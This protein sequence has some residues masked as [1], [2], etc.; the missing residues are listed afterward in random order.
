MSDSLKKTRE[1]YNGLA[2]T[3]DRI[4]ASNEPIIDDVNLFLELLRG[5]LVLDVGCGHGRDS[6]FF[7]NRGLTTVGF[8]LSI[9]LIR[10]AMNKSEYTCYVMADMRYP[11]F[12]A[13]T[14]NGL[15]VSASFH[16][17]DKQDASKSIMNQYETMKK[18]GVIYISVKKGDFAGFEESNRYNG[19]PRF[20][21]FYTKDEIN[22][23]VTKA[24]FTIHASKDYSHDQLDRE[25]IDVHAIK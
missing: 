9:S 1:A 23:L 7:S 19:A 3:Y 5:D 21:S 8:D 4:N 14:F 25:W 11:P 12:R 15:W 18:H 10:I 16:H 22:Q 13:N 2:E 24:G 17:L 20:Y 6:L